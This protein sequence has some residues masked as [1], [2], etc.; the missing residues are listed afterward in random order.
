MI[1]LDQLSFSEIYHLEIYC[2]TLK[3]HD[4]ER[5]C[6]ATGIH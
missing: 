4:M 6:K 2:A 5:V 1:E 3:N